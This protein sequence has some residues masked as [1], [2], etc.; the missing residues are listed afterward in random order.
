[1]L[2]PIKR[3]IFSVADIIKYGQIYGFEYEPDESLCR[4]C[5]IRYHWQG[6]YIT[7]DK[8][9]T[10]EREYTF[11]YPEERVKIDISLVVN[12]KHIHSIHVFDVKSLLAPFR[13]SGHLRDGFHID[14]WVTIMG[15]SVLTEMDIPVKQNIA[16]R[17][18]RLDILEQSIRGALSEIMI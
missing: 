12:R 18:L 10:K 9:I 2:V 4:P 17:V 8:V 11:A 1:M 13:D 15:H 3:H 7:D 14:Q 6:I 16:N 5:K